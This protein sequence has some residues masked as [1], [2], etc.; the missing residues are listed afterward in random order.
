MFFGFAFFAAFVAA[1]IYLGQGVEVQEIE[2]EVVGA[3]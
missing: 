2:Y 3:W 1:V